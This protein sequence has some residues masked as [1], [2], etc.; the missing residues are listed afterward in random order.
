MLFPS[1]VSSKSSRI[2]RLTGYS[3]KNGWQGMAFTAANFGFRHGALSLGAGSAHA[4]PLFCKRE[5][6]LHAPFQLQVRAGVCQ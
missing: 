5:G 2:V 4:D 6:P 1:R 3:S